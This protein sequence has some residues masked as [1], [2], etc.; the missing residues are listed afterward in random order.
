[1]I[2]D[3]ERSEVA[4]S[5]RIVARAAKIQEEKARPR[6]DLIAAWIALSTA[7]KGRIA[8]CDTSDVFDALAD[9]IEPSFHCDEYKET[10]FITNETNIVRKAYVVSVSDCDAVYKIPMWLYPTREAA[11]KKAREYTKRK[12]DDVFRRAI[13][14]EVKV[15]DE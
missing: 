9:L 8:F 7:I 11:E 13:V 2:S 3:K 15:M 14:N 1:M 5:F 4:K 10:D 12:H 6:P